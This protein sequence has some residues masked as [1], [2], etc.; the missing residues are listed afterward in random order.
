[1]SKHSPLARLAARL[2]LGGRDERT[3]RQLERQAKLVKQL[4]RDLSR[5]RDEQAKARRQSER[6]LV[7]LSRKLDRMDKTAAK[8]ENQKGRV[9]HY[10]DLEEGLATARLVLAEMPDLQPLRDRLALLGHAVGQV[11]TEGLFLEFGVFQGETIRC[12][13]SHHTGPIHGFDSFEGLPEPG[14][15]SLAA[16]EFDVGG[17]LPEVPDHVT[18]HKG[19]FDDS[20]PA[21]LETTAEPVAFLH[22]DCDI[23]S[24]TRTVFSLLGPR[25]QE[26]A[27]IVFD[28]YFNYP[29][30]RQHE[31]KAFAEAVERFGLSYEFIGRT[32]SRQVAVRLTAVGRDAAQV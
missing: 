20:L 9:R 8:R 17:T 28:E 5:L 27:V 6:A 30:W 7:E 16:G 25:L 21:F 14:G 10:I 12:I 24:S 19:W 1:M 15:V 2:G 29:A 11:E 18:L 3:I 26:G 32:D 13:A 23:Y 4:Q 31:V 22:I